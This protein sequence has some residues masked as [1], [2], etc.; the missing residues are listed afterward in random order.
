MADQEAS[1][2]IVL[3]VDDDYENLL[4]ARQML[5][6]YGAQVHT[7]RNGVEGLKLLEQITPTFVLLDLSMPQLDGWEMLEAIRARPETK[8]LPVFALTAHTGQ[9]T[10][11]KV[12]EAGFDGFIE[13]PFWLNTF[14][15]DIKHYLDEA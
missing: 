4:V 8:S 9:I 10:K 12:R 15:T 1:Q 2:W 6:L 13:K 11:E 3:L 14:L 5:E 7:A